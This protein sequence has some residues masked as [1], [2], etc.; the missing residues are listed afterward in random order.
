MGNVQK[1][2]SVG[3]LVEADLLYDQAAVMANHSNRTS[4][5]E[6]LLAGFLSGGC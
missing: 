3:I 1:I 5:G 2:W 4:L 6:G